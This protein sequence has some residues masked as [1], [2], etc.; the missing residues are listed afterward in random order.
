MLEAV[1]VLATVLQ[2]ARLVPTGPRPRMLPSITLR[3][4][5]PVPVRVERRR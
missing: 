1:L 2:R 3:P 4:A 5:G